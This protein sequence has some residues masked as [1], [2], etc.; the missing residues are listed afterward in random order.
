MRNYLTIAAVAAAAFA[1][2]ALAQDAEGDWT[3]AYIGVSAGYTGAKS[4]S[5]VALSGSWASES[6]AL[7]NEVVSRWAASQSLDDFN[8]GGQIGYNYQTSGAVLG[9]EADISALNG[10]DVVTRS[11]AST[12]FPSLTYT[13]TNRV[14]P[15]YIFSAKAKLG[16]ATGSTLFYVDGGWAWTKVDF[17]SDI[18]SNGGY[19]KSGRLSTTTDGFIVGGGIEHKFSPNVSAR[20]SYHYTDQGDETYV[21][22]YNTGSTFAP[23]GANYTET[24]TQDLRMHL[25]RVGLNFHF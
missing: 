15:K 18:T 13:Y 19:S 4:D 1:S 10:D 11:Q 8:F 7:Q 3:G 20:L 22:A 23:P 21:T 12:A 5:S 25:V 14:D 16:V 6:T 9:V 2:P 17:G 24:F